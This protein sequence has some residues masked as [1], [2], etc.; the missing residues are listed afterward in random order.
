MYSKQTSNTSN[1][2]SGTFLLSLLLISISASA[3]EVTTLPKLAIKPT[4]CVSMRQGQ[5]CF[6]NVDVSWQVDKKGD[7]CLYS[8][9]ASTPLKCWSNSHIGNFQADIFVTQNVTFTL[10]SQNN[11]VSIISSVLELA[12]V[13]T[14]QRLSH[15]SWRVF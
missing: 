5:D 7:Y 2:N 1:L 11:N 6:V 8:T 9:Q 13:H 10:K 15:S 4:Q 3:D 14:T 12:W